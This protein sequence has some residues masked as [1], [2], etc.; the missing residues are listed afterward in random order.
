MDRHRPFALVALV[1]AATYLAGWFD[2]IERDLLDL[3]SRLY[4]RPASGELLLVVIDPASLQALKRRPW[5]RRYHAEALM[6][7][8]AAGARRIAFDIDF[9]SSSTLEDDRALA[10]ALSAAGPDRVALAVHRQW[11][12]DEVFDAIP[13]P[14]FRDHVSPASVNV[15]PDPDGLV[16]EIPTVA[17]WAE[18]TVPTMPNWLLGWPSVAA[19]DVEIDFSIDPRTIPTLSFVDVLEGQF[20]PALVEGKRVLIGAAA[21]ELGDWRSVPRYRALPGPLVQALAFETLIQ[22]RSLWHLTG[23]PIALSGGVLTLLLGPWFVRL[24]WRR[25]LMLLAGSITSICVAAAALQ[26]LAAMVLDTTAPMLGLLL[27]FSVAMLGR[28]ERQARALVGQIGTLPA[29]DDMMRQLVDNSFDAIITF[30]GDGRVLSYN[31]SAE[32]IFGVPA[33]T[34]VGGALTELMPD[35]HGRALAALTDAGGTRE[36]RGRHQNGRYLPLEATFSRMQLDEQWVGI[37]ILRDIAERKAQQAE[38]ERL[39]LH[40]ALTGLPN[41]TLLSDRIANAI[42]GARRSALAMAVLLLDLDRFKDVNDTL[43]HQ[44]GDLLLTEVG[45][46]LQQPLRAADTVARLG[47]DEFAILLPGSTDLATACRVAERIVEALRQPFVIQGLILEVGVSIGVA[48]YPEHGAAP[49]RRC[50]DVRGQARPDRLRRLQRRVR[51]PQRPSA[52]LDRPAPP[53]DRERPAAPRVPA[54]DRRPHHRLGRRRGPD[55]L[56]AP[57][58][59]RDPAGGV[60]SQRRA[61]RSDQA[62]HALGDERRPAR[63]APLERRRLRSRHCGQSFG[64]VAAGSAIAG[65]RPGAASIVGAAARAADLR[66]H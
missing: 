62:A 9:S 45:P 37:A 17:G 64:E 20:D 58:A 25:G 46:R 43:G 44:V 7:L 1:I 57:R 19:P 8:L 51:H 59:R 2:P 61:D 55:P 63:V 11:S 65:G 4:P 35:D 6:R 50:G 16:R 48:L 49:A 21:I 52:D 30:A 41:R 40:D 38:L 13:L 42:S 15:Q 22:N 32:R 3:R 24:S 5:P 18:A 26:P 36:L 14:Q 54:Q 53:R 27:A 29:K 12:G 23:G 31:R 33:A 47:G 10:D 66:D 28:V 39:A 60:H 34:M 56:A